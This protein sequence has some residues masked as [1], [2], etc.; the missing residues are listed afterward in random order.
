VTNND[1]KMGF[2]GAFGDANFGD[3]AML[4]NDIC[5]I[6]AKENYIFTY[7]EKLS[8]QL[9]TA[10]LRDKIINIVMVQ[11][12][13]QAEKTLGDKYSIQYDDTVMTP[14]EV[15]ESI[16]EIDI[17]REKISEIDSLY[18]VGGG[19]FNRVWNA[20]HR[21]AKLLIIMAVIILADEERKPI[22]FGGNTFGPFDESTRFF[23]AFFSSLKNARYA[24][25]DDVFSPAC[26]RSIGL[27]EPI[28]ILP[29]DLYFIDAKLIQAA[30]RPDIDKLLPEK[31][32][33]LE[34]YASIDEIKDKINA[35][36]VFCAYMKDTY[37]LDTVFVPLDQGYGGEIQGEILSEKI[38]QMTYIGFFENEFRKIEDLQY[39]VKNASI[40]LC[41]RY[42]LF[43]VA[44]SQNVPVIHIQKKVCGDQRYYYCKVKG[45]L[46]EIFKS[47]IFK[48][49]DFMVT[50]I[51]EGLNLLKQSFNECVLQQQKLFN[52][53]KIQDEKKLFE[54]R[55]QYLN[56]IYKV[57]C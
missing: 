14:L 18:V 57:C 34:L 51:Y 26:M 55:K 22:I 2:V 37:C 20:S 41:Q 50:D 28:T 53:I 54:R 29:D 12:R 4:V 35:I 48:I 13:Y 31:Y 46:D 16:E 17:L 1:L 10:Y 52:S 39:I 40:V 43:V 6:H 33:V 8:K 49:S 11:S 3:Y 32:I 15:L 19:F 45:V 56:D 44:L 42:H 25:R 30:H 47:Q 7:N 9:E 27:C 24:T 36:K 21:K 38:E 23:A 5:A